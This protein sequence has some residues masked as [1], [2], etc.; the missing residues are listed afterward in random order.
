MAYAL[1]FNEANV[2]DRVD[3][4]IG[5][6]VTAGILSFVSFNQYQVLTNF[7]EY[8]R[9]SLLTLEDLELYFYSFGWFL[10]KEGLGQNPCSHCSRCEADEETDFFWEDGLPPDDA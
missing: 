8:E 1:D 3:E 10:Q 6:M 9:G 4:F 2:I 7:G 5:D